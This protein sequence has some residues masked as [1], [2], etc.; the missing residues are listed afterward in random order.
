MWKQLFKKNYIF[1]YGL[2]FVSLLFYLAFT[3]IGG[4]GDFWWLMALGRHWWET[5]QVT[6]YDMLSHTF[7]HGY[8]WNH[9]RL[10][11]IIVY[12]LFAWGKYLALDIFRFFLFIGTYFFL[13]KTISL[14]AIPADAGIGKSLGKNRHNIL[15]T[16]IMLA[17]TLWFLADRL[18]YRPELFSMLLS[19]I[20]LFLLFKDK[21]KASKFT[22]LVPILQLIWA[23]S[24]AGF[25]YGLAM[26]GI[27]FGAE[28]I[29]SLL[30]HRDNT[31][32]IIK[33]KR[34]KKLVLIFILSILATCLNSYGWQIY[35]LAYK[36]T[37]PQE[38]LSG[39]AEW[40]KYSWQNL[41]N[42]LNPLAI[43]FC[44][45]ILVLIFKIYQLT[46]STPTV[47]SACLAGRQATS[48][49]DPR[50]GGEGG[51]R[52]GVLIKLQH[53]PWEEICLLAFYLYSTLKHGRFAYLFSLIL[54]IIIARNIKHLFTILRIRGE[55]GSLKF[56][57]FL[58]LVL[59][60][61]FVLITY[62]F[63]QQPFGL[64]AKYTRYPKQATEFILEQKLP[65]KM[66]NEYLD[67]GYL[68]FYLYP[69]KLVSIDGR[70]PNLYTNDFFW[71]Y[72]QLA[73]K[74]I[75]E[76]MLNDYEINFIVWPRKSEFNQVMWSDKNWQQIYFDNLSVI[77][78]KKT[79]ENKPWLDKFG[80]SFMASFYDEKS[81]KQVCSEANLKETP[82]LK[83]NLIK[84]LEQ[85][86]S[87]KSDIAIY[88]QELALVYQTCQFQTQDLDKIKINLEQALKLKPD[89]Q[90][91]NYQLG[92]AY[93]Q[94]NDNEQAEKY[95]KQ[96]GSAR[97]YLV[98]LGTAQYNLGQYK[99]A[100][101][102][103]LKAR[104]LSGELDNKYYQTLGR[105]YYQLDQNKEAIEF[106][107]RYLDL[108]QDLTAE[109]YID[110]AWAYHDDGDVQ[111]AKVYLGI[112][113][114]K[115]NTYPQ[116]QALQELIGD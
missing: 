73:S 5:G 108:T 79:E 66:F 9:S 91:L 99:T 116:A 104:K 15:V 84:E 67:G 50:V 6:N 106:F 28:V 18:L 105:I 90:Q 49:L 37:L 101:K 38:A 16:F 77:Y 103:M 62:K 35:V 95:F 3:K 85:A 81:L 4:D 22:W 17:L 33:D 87:F 112:A 98:G 88:Y 24:H 2:F 26:I 41:F 107:Q 110:L 44:L 80:Y 13:Y 43:L 14:P 52:E 40:G 34:L 25:V 30:R 96:A 59:I 53:Y 93:L 75:R 47:A 100:L 1:V 51:D 23:N 31:L 70:T 114:V 61:V 69:K 58:H 64:D 7:P 19:A 97:P 86:I 46:R 36:L 89:D 11:D 60:F 76:K 45:S 92:F 102:T 21:Q 74:N 65:G 94:L 39:I 82:E 48:P 83:N 72:D 57:V 78:L 68:A 54:A 56:K 55:L 32:E 113:L 115:D 20:L 29:R 42:F 27:F 63:V 109:T 10:F 111:N 71:R 12:G 8:F